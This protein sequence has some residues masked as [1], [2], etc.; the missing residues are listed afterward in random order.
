M[1][2]YIFALFVFALSLVAAEYLFGLDIKELF[3]GAVDFI[4][5]IIV[6]G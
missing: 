3:A 1:K 2:R 6:G 5:R 4:R